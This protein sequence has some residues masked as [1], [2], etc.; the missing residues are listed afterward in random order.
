MSG[1]ACRTDRFGSSCT[2]SQD[3]IY[4]LYAFK[5]CSGHALNITYSTN[6]CTSDAA[7]SRLS[8]LNPFPAIFD[9]SGVPLF[10]DTPHPLSTVWSSS[11]IHGSEHPS[12][13]N[14]HVLLIICGG[15]VILASRYHTCRH[16]SDFIGPH[17]CI[18]GPEIVLSEDGEVSRNT[19]FTALAPMYMEIRCA[20]EYSSLTALRVEDVPVYLARHRRKREGMDSA[21][22]DR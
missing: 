20:T 6:Q 15:F 10:K 12:A 17:I 14:V 19:L 3:L 5:F 1:S 2:S 18:H 11:D 7:S 22:V 8:V 16:V 21:V 13:L 9:C 4:A